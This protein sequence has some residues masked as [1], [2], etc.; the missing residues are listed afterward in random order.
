MTA[1]SSRWL[2]LNEPSRLV[3]PSLLAPRGRGWRW[4][5]R[6]RA[7]RAA[8]TRPRRSPTGARAA[9]ARASWATRRPAARSTPPASRSRA[10]TTRSRC[11]G[12]AT[13]S[14]AGASPRRGGELQIYNYADYLNP[15]VIKEFGKREGVSV[16]VTT[17]DTLDEAFTKLSTGRL[18]VRR[19]LHRARPPVA[20][21]RPPAAS[22]PL[23]L[24][25]IPN[26]RKDGLAGAA[27]PVLR[28]RPALH[29]S[30]TRSTRPGSAGATTSSGL[31]PGQARP[32]VGRVLEGRAATRAASACSTTRARGSGMAL[33]R[34]G[35]TDL[36]TEDPALLERGR[37]RP[38]GAQ[39]RRAREG[40]DH[41]LRDA[42]GRPHRGCNQLWS[43]DMLN[44][45]ISYLPKGTSADVPLLLVPAR[46][47][48]RS[49]T[50]ASASAA[51]A[52]KPVIAH[53][54]LNYLLDAEGRATRT[55]SATSATSRR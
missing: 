2:A 51:K 26:L 9:A 49:S 5:R 32:A 10:A 8:R 22:Q 28:R 30:R 25:L 48:G 21:G 27:Q 35:V 43:G 41:R 4:S 40:H 31:R 33:M 47:A 19:H 11:R 7:S 55:S 18:R 45:V 42:A 44:A 39:R 36:N 46:R 15:A 53:R 16:R 54:F 3:A 38:R 29:A 50:T 12:S 23:N 13:R 1:G 20:A 14:K 34:R 17:F 52:A 6:R 37:R 24:D